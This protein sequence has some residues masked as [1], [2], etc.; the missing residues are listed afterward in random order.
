MVFNNL[1]I[2]L[3]QKANKFKSNF[4]QTDWWFGL[5]SYIYIYIYIYIHTY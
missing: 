1:N 3:Y 5:S 2:I 4:S